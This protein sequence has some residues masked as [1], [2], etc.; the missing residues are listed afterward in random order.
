MH[1]AT[2]RAM[3][4]KQ[5]THHARLL[6]I[7]PALLLFVDGLEHATLR[8]SGVQWWWLWG[9]LS[10]ATPAALTRQAVMEF[11]SEPL[12]AVLDLVLCNGIATLIVLLV[13]TISERAWACATRLRRIQ[14]QIP[15]PFFKLLHASHA[16]AH[17]FPHPPAA[18]MRGFVAGAG[19][20][21]RGWQVRGDVCVFAK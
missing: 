4:C 17:P 16:H 19:A 3:F 21:A 6:L 15:P 5:I 7:P 10:V 14:H 9:K 12:W 2:A 20:M 18:M 11:I 13:E 1:A 8:L